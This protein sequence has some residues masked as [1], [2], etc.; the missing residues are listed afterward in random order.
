MKIIKDDLWNSRD[1]II[2]VSGNSFIGSKGELVM[3]KG[4]PG[5]GFKAYY[6]T[7]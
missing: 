5:S 4:K 7:D 1:R 3:G 6:L 2:L